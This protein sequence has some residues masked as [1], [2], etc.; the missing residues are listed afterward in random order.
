MTGEE[1]VFKINMKEDSARVSFENATNVGP[2]KKKRWNMVKFN[3]IKQHI[4]LYT[5][6]V[7]GPRSF[8]VSHSNMV[9]V[10]DL[11]S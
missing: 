3:A 9:S 6:M 7:L 8:L 10:F 2:L 11:L 4:A 5:S 1:S